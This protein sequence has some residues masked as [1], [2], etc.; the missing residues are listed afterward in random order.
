MVSAVSSHQAFGFMMCAQAIEL[1]ARKILGLLE[2]IYGLYHFT[3]KLQTPQRVSSHHRTQKQ[4]PGWR[5]TSCC[6]H[7]FKH[8]PARAVDN[9]GF[10]LLSPA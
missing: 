4:L 6:D 8:D 9:E 5:P 10:L 3:R 1:L 2:R 7:R